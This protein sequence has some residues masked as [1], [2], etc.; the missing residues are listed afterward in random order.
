MSSKYLTRHEEHVL[1]AILNLRDEAYLVTIQD[2]LRKHAKT[3]YSFGTLYVS[4]KR[5]ERAGYLESIIGES[6]AKRGGKA[7]K[8]Y[9]LTKEGYKILKETQ[10]VNEAMWINFGDLTF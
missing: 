4:L 6:I 2:F 7:I 8:Y 3:N 1:L 9:R 10:K 5:L